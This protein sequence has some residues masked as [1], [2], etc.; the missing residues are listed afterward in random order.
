MTRTTC[1]RQLTPEEAAHYRYLC[2]QVE[3]ELPDLI[4][5][6]VDFRYLILL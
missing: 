2:E 4:V 3:G 6:Q 5:R 1:D